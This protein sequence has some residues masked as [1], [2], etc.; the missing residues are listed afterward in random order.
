M[1]G[2]NNRFALEQCYRKPIWDILV[3]RYTEHG[4]LRDLA[5]AI[6][7]SRATI[8]VWLAEIGKS[9]IHLRRTALMVRKR[10]EDRDGSK[11]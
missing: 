10:E 11:E 6:G 8:S 3:E 9:A 1:P 2:R 7:V 5:K 4:G